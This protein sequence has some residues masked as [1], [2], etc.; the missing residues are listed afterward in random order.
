[1]V[2]LAVCLSLVPVFLVVAA[3]DA[4]T[5]LSGGAYTVDAVDSVAYLQ[6]GPLADDKERKR[7]ADGLEALKQKWVMPFLAGGPWGRGPLSNAE[8]CV[9]CHDNN[10]RGRVP[11]AAGEPLRSV[12]V[13]LSITPEGA[14]GQA[15]P[16]P[17]YGEQFNSL[18]VEDQ[19]AGEGEA[20]IRWEERA[21]SY[22]DGE[23]IRLRAPT[24]EFRYL[25]YGPIGDNAITSIRIA[26]AL[27]GLGLIEAVPDQQIL[28]LA[29]LEKPHGIKGR[30][31][32]VTDLASKRKVIGRFGLKANQP[33]LPQQIMAAFHEDMGVT[34]NLFPEEVCT[35]VQKAC[36]AAVPAARP[37]MLANQFNPLLFF[38]RAGAVPARRG[39][40][41]P[42]AKRGEA[43]FAAAACSSCHVPELTTGPATSLAGLA[44]QV[45]RPYTDLLLHD[46][47]EELAD[48]RPDFD[49]NGREWRTAPLWGLGLLRHVSGATD[50]LH[51]GR[52]R[53]AEEAIAW[54]DGEGRYS[55]EAFLAMSREER[56]ALLK[57][58]DSL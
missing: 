22:A 31:N 28:A 34:S 19:V 3:E 10:G 41:D 21:V 49:A 58:L 54:H 20:L 57:F 18:G 38:L 27:I 53:S 51:D 2:R 37:E 13:R 8:S 40:D 46:M 6:P 43:L 47:G 36:L 9:D 55:R 44:H 52:A 32:Y 25:A 7:F 26:P 1:M 5:A 23:V 11:S 39:L 12:L 33:N 56:R 48:G 4:P 16:H 17:L 29:K 50:L 42:E 35:T 24:I 15:R 30:P 14:P 45:I